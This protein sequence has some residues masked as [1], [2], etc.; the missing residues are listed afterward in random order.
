M[1]LQAKDPCS[2]A[3]LNAMDADD[4]AAAGV[5]SHISNILSAN[6]AGP[7]ALLEAL[8]AVQ[9]QL[10]AA[11]GADGHLATWLAGQHSIQETAAEIDRLMQV[12][13]LTWQDLSIT[14]RLCLARLPF[15]GTCLLGQVM[16]L[17]H[18]LLA[19]FGR[20][21]HIKSRC[22]DRKQEH[23]S[24]GWCVLLQVVEAVDASVDDAV[25]FRFFSVNARQA[26]SELMSRA[27][28]SRHALQRWMQEQWHA[29]NTAQIARW[30]SPCRGNHA[31]CHLQ[32]I[33]TM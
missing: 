15:L 9:Q 22:A 19:R 10:E 3:L 17:C 27:L 25:W 13:Q 16:H 2:N 31:A 18:L 33:H 12:G 7:V 23:C 5:R 6:M 14:A 32:H 4:P 24:Q 30:A 20:A 26:K 28:G 11:E 1:V 29:S 8:A 21:Y